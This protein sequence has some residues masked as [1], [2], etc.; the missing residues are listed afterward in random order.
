[1]DPRSIEQGNFETNSR[2]FP[3]QL[4]HSFP[5]PQQRLRFGWAKSRRQPQKKMDSDITQPDTPKFREARPLFPFGCP[6]SVHHRIM[7]SSL[8]RRRLPL[9]KVGPNIRVA[10]EPVIWSYRRKG[11]RLPPPNPTPSTSSSKAI[12]LKDG[13]TSQ[14]GGG[15]PSSFQPQVRTHTHPS[16]RW[17]KEKERRKPTTNS[18]QTPRGTHHKSEASESQTKRK[19]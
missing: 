6:P 7:P 18:N 19:K 10:D 9:A 16:L 13:P 1:V 8:E 5:R 2:I 14:D 3:N 12:I 11:G 17:I 4:F 15:S